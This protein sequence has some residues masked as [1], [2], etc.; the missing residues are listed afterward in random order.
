M[1]QERE[2]RQ[3]QHQQPAPAELLQLQMLQSAYRR[4]KVTSRPSTGSCG[5]L[6]G[7]ES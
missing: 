6:S 2:E 4:V 5:P 7:F 3:G 1:H